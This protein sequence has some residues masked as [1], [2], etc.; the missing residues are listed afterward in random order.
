MAAEPLALI[1]L[2]LTWDFGKTSSTKSRVFVVRK[3]T[4]VIGCAQRKLMA[5]H[6]NTRLSFSGIL[7]FNTACQLANSRD[8]VWILTTT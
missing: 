4:E 6:P 1:R 3:R 2:L 7:S 5:L 8:L